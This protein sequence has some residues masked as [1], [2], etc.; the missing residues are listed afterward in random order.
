MDSRT[1][2]AF[3]YPNVRWRCIRCA[4]CC[5]DRGSHQRRIVLLEGEVEEICRH[6]CWQRE[7]FAKPTGYEPYVASM[8]K[9]NGRCVFL[10]GNSCSIYE[11]RPLVCRFYPFWLTREDS[12]Y[13]FRVTAEC[14][15]IGKG[16]IVRQEHFLSL[17]RAAMDRNLKAFGD[18][19][20][21]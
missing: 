1:I 14:P 20:K 19:A 4:T 21:T 6:T 18:R 15:G 5:K 7:D 16:E 13:M 2:P 3:T 8:R 17:I 11:I 9:I 12:I 10:D